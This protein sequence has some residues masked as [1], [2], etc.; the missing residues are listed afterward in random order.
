MKD[1]NPDAIRNIAFIGH[2]GSGK[3][4]LSEV[5]LYTGKETNRIGK[6]EEGNTLS[7]FNPNEVE[8]QISVA[9]TSLHLDWKDSKINLI[10][11]P[12]YSDFIGQVI[13]GLHVVDTAVAVIKSAEG[14]EVGTELTWEY[15][16]KRNLPSAII[17]NKVDNEHSTFN[18]TVNVIKDRLSQDATIISMPLNEGINFDGVVDLIK[19]KAFTYGEPGSRKVTE[20]QIPDDLKETVETMR[21]ELIEKV[22]ESSEELMNKFFEEGTLNDDD[23]KKGIQTA[24]LNGALIPIFAMSGD[25]AVGMNSF[26]DFVV[27]FF[28]SPVDMPLA[29]GKL[30]DEDIEVKCD[31]DGEPVLQVFKSLSEQHVGELSIFRVYSGKLT[32]GMDL[33][34]ISKNKSE[35]LGQLF[36]LNGKNRTEVS[37]LIAGDIG[38]V[39]K[40]KDTHTSDTLAS[41]SYS[42]TMTPIEYPKPVIRGAVQ[43]RAKGDEDKISSGLHTVHEEDPTLAVKFEPELGQTIVSGQGELQLSLAIKL[44]K[45]RYGVEV[46]LVEPRIPYRETIKGRCDDAEFKHKKQS[47]GRGQYGH[48]HLKLEPLPRGTGFEFVDAIV[49][50]VVPGRFIPAV[51]KGLKEIMAKGILTGSTVIDIRVTLFDGTFHSVDSD[52]VSFKI[53]ASQAFKRGFMEAKPVI[54]EPIYDIQVKVPE[55]FMGDVMGD[56]SSRRGKISGMESEG[57]F[58]VIKAKIP[59]AELYKYS[60]H[61]RSLTSGRGMH[62]RAFSHYEDLPKEVESKVIEDYKKSKEEE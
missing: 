1:Y 14:V 22:A 60:T 23:L 24:I 42:V 3:T 36:V 30:N 61:L 41:K 10:D 53:A 17:I 7:D 49:G 45:D 6:I 59:L 48:V 33:V 62:T 29:K 39:V 26:L 16:Q 32:A 12:G 35:R 58:Q 38:A 25:K 19:M 34:N 52:E 47:G 9:A 4:T 8:R 27:D 31:P 56:I 46:D 40:L 2:G 50:G 51:E 28:P 43:P 57:P 5:L 55:E 54:L 13:S 44:L 11:T 37:S 21:E 20:A 18:E 15:V